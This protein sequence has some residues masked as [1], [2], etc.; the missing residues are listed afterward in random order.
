MS[1]VSTS[2]SKI[3]TNSQVFARA[4]FLVTYLELLR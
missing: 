1:F 2:I 4:Y 3:G